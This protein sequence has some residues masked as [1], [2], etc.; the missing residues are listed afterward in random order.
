MSNKPNA[1]RTVRWQKE[2]DDR[3]PSE[4]QA[5]D[6]S[7]NCNLSDI[8]RA[9]IED[10]R[11]PPATE[12]RI[13]YQDCWRSIKKAPGVP[14]G[15]TYARLIVKTGIASSLTPLGQLLSPGWLLRFST[16]SHLCDGT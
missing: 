10:S 1:T 7:V 3:T 6:V 11:L 16:Q 13:K 8:R 4:W 15:D 14:E 2:I 5:T 9:V 12:V